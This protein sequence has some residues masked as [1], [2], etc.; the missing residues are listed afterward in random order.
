MV[1]GLIRTLRRHRH[2]DHNGQS[3]TPTLE[4]CAWRD[5]QPNPIPR[6]YH[7][8]GQTSVA[9]QQ[10]GPPRPDV[11]THQQLAQPDRAEARESKLQHQG[12]PRARNRPQRHSTRTRARLVPMSLQQ[13]YEYWLKATSANV[14]RGPQTPPPCSR[15][16]QAPESPDQA[17]EH[18]Q[19]ATNGKTAPQVPKGSSRGQESM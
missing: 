19:K 2:V 8:Q 10:K 12:I 13:L 16:P 1:P 6:A 11:P 17:A 7:G 5:R 15:C 18:Q 4:S 14:Q 9:L 3:R